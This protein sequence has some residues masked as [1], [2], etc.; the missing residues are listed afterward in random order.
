MD[1][2]GGSEACEG[3][4]GICEVAACPDIDEYRECH[5]PAGEGCSK[6]EGELVRIVCGTHSCIIRM[7]R[8]ID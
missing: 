7:K 3:D 2:R 4:A 1:D 6:G 8:L 5:Q